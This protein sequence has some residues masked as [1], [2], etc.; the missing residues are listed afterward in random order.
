[1]ENTLALDGSE[2]ILRAAE[3]G[4][5]IAIGRRPMVDRWLDEGRLVAPFG[6]A[7]ESGCAYYLVYCDADELSVPARRVARWLVGISKG[8]EA[9]KALFA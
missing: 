1:L 9:A 2:Q 8:E 5:G 3:A 4:L 7:D 6:A